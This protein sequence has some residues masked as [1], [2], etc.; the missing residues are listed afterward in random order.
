MP[1][2]PAAALLA[3][4]I[5]AAATGAAAAGSVLVSAASSLKEA[6]QEAAERFEVRHPGTGVVVNAAASGVL[7]RQIEE[8]APVDL[9]VSASPDEIERLERAGRIDVGAAR[10]VASN[11][12]VVVVPAGSSPP[13]TLAG[14]AAP[15]FDRI[16]IGNPRTVPAGRYAEQA[17]RWVGVLNA[18]AT[19]L[20]PG[21]SVRQVLEY[22]ARGEVAAGIVY[23]TDPRAM[24]ERVVTGPEAPRGSHDPIVYLVAPLRDAPHPTDAAALMAFLL[25]EEGRSILARRGFLPPPPR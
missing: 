10:P 3:A 25:S 17:L 1:R 22:V 2:R 20:I 12:L 15:R 18:L 6:I 9:F 19:R 13:A 21:E 5:A 4:V 23:A 16:A 24:G 14:L 7:L 11:R 8:D